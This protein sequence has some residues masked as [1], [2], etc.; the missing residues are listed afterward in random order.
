MARPLPEHVDFRTEQKILHLNYCRSSTFLW[1][2]LLR[3]KPQHLVAVLDASLGGDNEGFGGNAMVRGEAS[4][5]V[6]YIIDMFDIFSS[7]T[8]VAPNM[9]P[10]FW[11]LLQD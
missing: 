9:T 4:I 11:I 5:I 7:Q 8:D 2:G 3:I 6:G 1:K 10:A